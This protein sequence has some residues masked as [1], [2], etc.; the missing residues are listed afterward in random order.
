MQKGLNIIF[1]TGIIT[2]F[3][4]IEYKTIKQKLTGELTLHFE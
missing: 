2:F 4:N 3:Q 1:K